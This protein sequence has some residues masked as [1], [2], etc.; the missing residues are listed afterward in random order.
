MDQPNKTQTA[1]PR[2][3]P[4]DE[5]PSPHFFSLDTGIGLEL[6][7]SAR[8][9]NA[10]LGQLDVS[11][12]GSQLYATAQNHLRLLLQLLHMGVGRGQHERELQLETAHTA[13]QTG[14]F[15]EDAGMLDEAEWH[16]HHGINMA[17]TAGGKDFIVYGL[18]R[19]AAVALARENPKLCLSRLALA[20]HEAGEGSPWRSFMLMFAVEAHGRLGDGKTAEAALAKAD[21]LYDSREQDLVPDWAFWLPRPSASSIAA[22]SFLELNPKLSASLYEGALGQL[23]TQFVRSRLHLL[24][25][26]ARAKLALGETDLAL[27]AAG[28][29]LRSLSSMGGAVPRVET[30]LVK[31]EARL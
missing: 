3:A 10:E 14:W 31:F 24:A 26:L 16:Y 13:C 27:S 19:L 17:R 11:L 8:R 9:Q 20:G 12:G 4:E 30:L 22:R 18:T 28:E 21:A 7:E 25:G 5:T 15:A 23:S 6:I 1:I 2:A 29:A